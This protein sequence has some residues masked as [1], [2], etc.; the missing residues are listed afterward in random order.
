MSGVVADTVQKIEGQGCARCSLAATAAMVTVAVTMARC[1]VDY[2]FVSRT[3][4]SRAA[5]TEWQKVWDGR[6]KERGENGGRVKEKEGWEKR[7]RVAG[8]GRVE[9]TPELSRWKICMDSLRVEK[10]KKK[11]QTVTYSRVDVDGNGEG[12]RVA[13]PKTIERNFYLW[14]FALLFFGL[15]LWK[16]TVNWCPRI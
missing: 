1:I 16:F 7:E 3:A 9:Y 6:R 11:N 13:L 15:F 10:K 4:V 2:K 8:S 12:N 5:T 14:F